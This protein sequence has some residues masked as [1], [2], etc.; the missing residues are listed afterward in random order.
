LSKWHRKLMDGVLEHG[1]V[2][3]PSGREFA[4]PNAQRLR[5]GRITNATN[6]VN[7]PVQSFAT[8]DIVPLACIR[9]LRRWG[10]LRSRLILTVHDSIVVDVHPDELD[11]VKNVL[12]DAML[13]VKDDL[14]KRFNY[15][16]VLPF[17]IEIE[18][19][20]NWM[21]MADVPVD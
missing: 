14:I 9:A 15:E 7:Y 12:K 1:I 2:R 3:I 10:D 21:T 19:G 13:G 5:S 20:T 4:F 8:A 17:D 16:P 11:Q 6:V 18:A